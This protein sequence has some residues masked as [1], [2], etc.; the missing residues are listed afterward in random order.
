MPGRG[1]KH[2]QQHGRSQTN[3]CFCR[4]ISVVLNSLHTPFLFVA[5][6]S[7]TRGRPRCNIG[8]TQ[9]FRLRYS[10]IHTLNTR[11]LTYILMDRLRRVIETTWVHSI[12]LVLRRQYSQQNTHMGLMKTANTS[13]VRGF[14]LC[15]ILRVNN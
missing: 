4:N 11:R 8:H 14:F 5:T 6:Y 7:K 15:S 9:L 12:F 1:R 10:V 3:P 13:Q 2:E